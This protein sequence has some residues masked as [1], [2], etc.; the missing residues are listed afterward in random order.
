MTARFLR[1]FRGLFL[2]FFI[3]YIDIKIYNAIII[4]KVQKEKIVYADG[5]SEGMSQ[6]VATIPTSPMTYLFARVLNAGPSGP[7]PSRTN[8]HEE[9]EVVYS[10]ERNAAQ[11]TRK[12][13]GTEHTV[14]V[15]DP[16]GTL[17]GGGKVMGKL[18]FFLMQ[19][20]QASGYAREVAFPISRLV[21]LGMY[22]N[23]DTARRGV[24]TFMERMM[25][26]RFSKSVMN[27]KDGKMVKSHSG[28]VLFYNYSISGGVVT[29][30]VNDKVPTELV[31]DFFTIF[32]QFAYGLGNNAFFIVHYVMYLARQQGATLAAKGGKFGIRLD[33]VRQ[34]LELPTPDK[35]KN[36]KYKEKIQA[37]IENA[38]DGIS[39]ALG[40]NA[41]MLGEYGFSIA[42]RQRGEGGIKAWL[43]GEVEVILS[44]T[45]ASRFVAIA[46]RKR[47][48]YDE[49]YGT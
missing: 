30:S 16:E 14:T 7:S 23:N 45:L 33:S 39:V 34:Y 41:E 46:E 37:P 47:G 48:S 38:I 1:E 31:A 17:K 9:M 11:Y 2:S 22:G 13:R 6:M 28:G 44:S 12:N 10:E 24:K 5:K 36:F 19:E 43:S 8:R 3:T 26:I 15:F 25:R 40:R 35:V 20:W 27:G 42:L 32:P 18:F 29:V 4:K 49:K 21:K